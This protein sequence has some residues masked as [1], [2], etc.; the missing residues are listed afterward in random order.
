VAVREQPGDGRQRRVLRDLD[1]VALTGQRGEQLS[2]AV[3][4]EVPEVEPLPVGAAR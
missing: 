2:L 3:V 4:G 1:P